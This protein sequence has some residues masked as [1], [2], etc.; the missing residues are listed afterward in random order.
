[1]PDHPRPYKAFGYPV[2]PMLYI[3]LA[4]FICIV[5]LRF[6]PTYTW[7]GLIIVLAGLPIYYL[8]EKR[9]KNE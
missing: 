1:M 7:P 9:R 2:V 3:A 8:L 5:L 6:K 4:S